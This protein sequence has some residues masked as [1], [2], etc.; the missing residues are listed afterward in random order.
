MKVV[1]KRAILVASF[2]AGAVGG[3]IIGSHVFAGAL[4]LI[5]GLIGTIYSFWSSEMRQDESDLMQQAMVD[6]FIASGAGNP[7]TKLVNRKLSRGG[8]QYVI[9]ELE[10]ALELDPDD[11]EALAFTSGSEPFTSG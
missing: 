5:A 11:A 1:L 7:Y 4:L 8:V 10:R 2:V 3:V 6:L 9:P